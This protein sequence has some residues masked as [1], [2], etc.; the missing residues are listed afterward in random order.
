MALSTIRGIVALVVILT[1]QVSR[2]QTYY[3]RPTGSDSNTGLSTTSPF[4]TIQKAVNVASAAG[5]VIYV[6]PG[7][8][9]EQVTFS[10]ST[11]RGNSA[12]PIRLV[13]DT[14]GTRFGVSPG[15]VTI[16][17]SSSRSY[18]IYLSGCGDWSFEKLTFSGQSY[19]NA[20][21]QS[22]NGGLTFDD[23]V[24][25]VTTTYGLYIAYGQNITVNSCTFTRSTGQRLCTYLYQTAGN[26]MVLTGNRIQLTGSSYLKAS[27]GKGSVPHTVYGLIALPYVNGPNTVIIQNNIVSDATYGIYCYLPYANASTSLTISNN[28]AEGCY[29]GNYIYAQAPIKPVISNNIVGNSYIAYIHAPAGTVDSHLIY[30]MGYNPCG[31]NWLTCGHL[32][33]ATKRN[34]MIN[35]TPTY[36]NAAN[37]DFTL[38]GTIGVDQGTETGAAATDI[39][40]A[41]RPRDADGDGK[42][43]YDLGPFESGTVVE[44]K[45][46]V[47][48]WRETSKF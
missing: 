16:E 39:L 31:T 25:A 21:C 11:K 27:Q 47:V 15:S 46:R 2:G 43:E 37:G 36:A 30:N 1:A 22:P 48:R 8:Y 23:C 9:P 28:V 19:A 14:A 20:F 33:A 32:T 26:K 10:T 35:Q 41:T 3:V 4:K 44:N 13:G 7:S 5:T 45:L 24:F 34:I 6:A 42:A 38:T 29:Y 18:G 17:G 12:N 40:G